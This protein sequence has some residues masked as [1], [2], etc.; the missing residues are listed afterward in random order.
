MSALLGIRFEEPFSQKPERLWV[1]A[2]GHTSRAFFEV[3][4]VEEAVVPPACL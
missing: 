2:P 3:L 4:G 1:E